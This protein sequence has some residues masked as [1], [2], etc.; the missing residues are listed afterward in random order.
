MTVRH[1]ASFVF[2]V[3]GTKARVTELGQEEVRLIADVNLVEMVTG[4]QLD[5][6]DEFVLIMGTYCDL[7][8]IRINIDSFVERRN[9]NRDRRFGVS[10][11]EVNNRIC[12]RLIN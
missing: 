1:D 8:I 6:S 4:V 10:A 11:K 7:I 2:G 3:E 12:V 5:C 9:S